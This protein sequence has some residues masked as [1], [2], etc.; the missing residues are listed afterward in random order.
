MSRLNRDDDE[1]EAKYDD[2]EDEMEEDEMDFDEDESDVDDM[3]VDEYQ[4]EYVEGMPRGED[5]LMQNFL[6]SNELADEQNNVIGTKIQ[7]FEAL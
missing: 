6:A 5:W 3:D 4:D 1:E 7:E 2:S